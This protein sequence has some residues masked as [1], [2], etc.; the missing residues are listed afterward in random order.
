LR[1]IS[2]RLWIPYQVAYEYYDNV[3]SVISDEINKY[4]KIISFISS[5]E[6]P[7]KGEID[8]DLRRKH[9][10]SSEILA[11]LNKKIAGFELEFDKNLKIIE[12]GIKEEIKN[13]PKRENLEGINEIIISLFNGKVGKPF[14]IKELEQIS[15]EGAKRYNFLLPHGY[16][17]KKIRWV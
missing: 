2:D 15:E 7:K 6:K 13:Y 16:K 10:S 1:K 17:D 11:N 14:S 9:T 12:N 8:K 4:N 5:I 3:S